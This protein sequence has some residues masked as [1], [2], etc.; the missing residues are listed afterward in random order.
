MVVEAK[1][2]SALNALAVAV[3]EAAVALLE[4][5][6]DVIGRRDGSQNRRGH[7]AG[8][9]HGEKRRHFGKECK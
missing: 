1:V 2:K 7:Q 8:K 5:E 9:N 3:A 6:G 4:F